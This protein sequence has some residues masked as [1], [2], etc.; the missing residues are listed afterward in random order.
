[1]RSAGMKVWPMPPGIGLRMSVWGFTRV[2]SAHMM[3]SIV[4]VD[5][6]AHRDGQRMPWEQ[7]RIAPRKLRCQ[8]SSI[9]LRFFTWMMQPPQSVMQ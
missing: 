3:S 4:Y 5:V 1:M 9:L 7:A 6:L 2:V 8:P